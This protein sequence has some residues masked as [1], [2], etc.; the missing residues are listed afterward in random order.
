VL[1]F[2]SQIKLFGHGR[3]RSKWEGPFTVIEFAP[4][5]IVTL[6]NDE[7]EIFKVNGHCLKIFLEPDNTEYAIIKFVEGP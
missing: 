4:H 2:N 3:L 7:G 6:K 5:R 1:L